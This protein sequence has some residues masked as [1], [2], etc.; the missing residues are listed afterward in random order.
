MSDSHTSTDSESSGPKGAKVFNRQELVTQVAEKTGL[1]KAQAV[2]A[3]LAVLDCAS[4]ALKEG[5]E[6]RFAGFGVFQVSERKAGKGRDP[7]SGA[8]I[9]IPESKSVRFRPGKVLREL[10]ADTAV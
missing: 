2:A 8:E 3:V 4:S 5:K 6:V 1:P 9:D 10:V 7:R